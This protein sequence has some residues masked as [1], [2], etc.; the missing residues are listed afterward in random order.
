MD[1]TALETLIADAAKGGD[2]LA[3]LVLRLDLLE[4]KVTVALAEEDDDADEEA[5]TRPATAISL[6]IRLSALANARAYYT[7]KKA[8]AAKTA[9]TV[10]AAKSAVKV[11]EKKAA[12]AAANIKVVASIRSVRTPMWW[13]KFD[14]FVSSENLLVLL[15]RDAQQAE[16]L[17]R[18]HLRPRD[19]YV[20]ADVGG[21][22]VAIVRHHG[23]EGEVPPLS[24]AQAGNAVLCRSEAWGS[25][26]V[27]SAWYVAAHQVTKESGH[28]FRLPTG[29]FGTHGQKHYLPPSPLV[30]GVG[31]LFRVG[32]GSVA[33]HAADRRVRS[34]GDDEAS[35]SAAPPSD[36]EEE[37]E[38][39]EGEEE[40][41]EGEPVEAA[42]REEETPAAVAPPAAAGAA[43]AAEEAAAAA[44]AAEAAAEEEEEA[45]EEEDDS[46]L[47]MLPG[48]GFRVSSA[49]SKPA[50]TPDAAGSAAS[51]EGAAA[52]KHSLKPRLTAKERRL[53]KKGRGDEVPVSKG[54]TAPERASERSSAAEEGEEGGEGE[55][56]PAD[57]S[58]PA[59][60]TAARQ[61]SSA[62]SAASASAASAS[63]ASASS[64][65]S[66]R[67]KDA[68]VRG[69][70]GKLKRMKERCALRVRTL[71][72]PVFSPHAPPCPQVRRPG[73]GGA[74]LVH[75]DPRIVGQVEA[76]TRGGGG[77]GGG[78]G[79]AGGGG[80]Q[81]GAQGGAPRQGRGA[82][83]GEREAVCR[84]RRRARGQAQR[85]EGGGAGR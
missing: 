20:H 75:A 14:W 6:D 67:A 21:A 17:V 57:I 55:G 62:S 48:G 70:H 79:E 43:A 7:E 25:K 74:R 38:G 68:P 35:G 42:A 44:E 69:K 71:P 56:G 53:L 77:G 12:K 65:A 49:A 27:I 66:S 41:G 1:W 40:G 64:A 8:A 47:R 58:D 80:G 22:P 59:I 28:G 52:P 84:R 29:I 82:A 24:L 54:G 39:E 83:G 37:G 33:R 10:E 46:V 5:L 76:R 31:L 34:G 16:M 50:A 73:R 51:S 13:E 15:A 36:G 72:A 26:A 85:Q 19:S 61:L 78:G 63:A 23:G 3:A 11:A 81:G 2:E 18:R 9:R 30:M 32:L 60:P 45:E 4:H